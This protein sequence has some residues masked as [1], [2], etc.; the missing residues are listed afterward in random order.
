MVYYPLNLSAFRSFFFSLSLPVFP[1][2]AFAVEKLAFNN[3][4]TGAVSRYLLVINL[5]FLMYGFSLTIYTFVHIAYGLFIAFDQKSCVFWL[6]CFFKSYWYTI[7][8]SFI[9]SGCC[10]SSHLS[11]NSWN[12]ISSARNSYVSICNIWVYDWLF[13]VLCIKISW[14]NLSRR[15][16][17]AE[18][19]CMCHYFV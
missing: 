11:Y 13:T 4:I 3:I 7:D 16:I 14:S 15:H 12:C 8:L 5:T 2:G 17:E 9:F 1:L 10:R 18:K 6:Y 19:K